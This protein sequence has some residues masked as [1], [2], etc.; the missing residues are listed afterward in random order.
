VPAEN[1]SARCPTQGSPRLHVATRAQ[2]ALPGLQGPISLVV[3]KAR[4]SLLPRAARPAEECLMVGLDA[5]VVTTVPTVGVLTTIQGKGGLIMCAAQRLLLQTRAER[6]L[7]GGLL[8]PDCLGLPPAIAREARP[9]GLAR[10]RG[11]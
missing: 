6:A 11:V 3:V 7:L 2:H 9:T 4:T 1:S 5:A 8:L 10:G